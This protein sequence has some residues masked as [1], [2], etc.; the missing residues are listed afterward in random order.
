MK[1]IPDSQTDIDIVKIL[2][3]SIHSFKTEKE[4][5]LIR[6]RNLLPK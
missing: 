6:F 4:N 3:H 1:D 5:Y 2:T